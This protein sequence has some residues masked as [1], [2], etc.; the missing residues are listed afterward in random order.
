MLDL[1]ALPL[2]APDGLQRPGVFLVSPVD[3]HNSSE[4]GLVG[5]IDLAHWMKPPFSK[6]APCS[7]EMLIVESSMFPD[8]F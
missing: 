3:A 7:R 8:D 2:I 4:L 5:E 1:A 6:Q